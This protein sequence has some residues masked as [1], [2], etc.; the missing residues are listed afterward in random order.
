MN[1]MNSSVDK[2]AESVFSDYITD[3]Q[4]QTVRFQYDSKSKEVI[5]K[6]ISDPFLKG[7]IPLNWLTIAAQLPG[8]TLNVALAIRWLSGMNPRSHIKLTRKALA[9]FHVSSDATFDGLKRLES[10]GLIRVQRFPGKRPLIEVLEIP[11]DPTKL[12]PK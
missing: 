3:D 6:R 5:K 4:I 12:A 7:P 1:A 9:L 10:K 11:K 8:K 2:K